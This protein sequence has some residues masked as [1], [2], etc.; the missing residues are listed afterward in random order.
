MSKK[1]SISEGESRLEAEVAA[2]RGVISRRQEE[3]AKD[4]GSEASE[5]PYGREGQWS[6]GKLLSPWRSQKPAR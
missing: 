4:S 2:A 3:S 6:W 1:Q 5:G